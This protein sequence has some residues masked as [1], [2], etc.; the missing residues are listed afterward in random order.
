MGEIWQG[1]LQRIFEKVLAK[2][3]GWKDINGCQFAK[4][5]ERLGLIHFYKR[6]TEDA[7]F[8]SLPVEVQEK[9]TNP[10]QLVVNTFE[11]FFL[12]MFLSLFSNA[13]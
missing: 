8:K 4:A 13:C 9:I 7:R 6:V 3:I 1:C 11:M 10:Q 2:K 5:K 12:V